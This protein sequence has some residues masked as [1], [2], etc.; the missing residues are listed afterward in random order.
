M[1]PRAKAVRHCLP[2]RSPD[3]LEG[4]TDGYDVLLR[5]GGIAH[6]RPLRTDDRQALHELVDRSSERSAYLRFFTG[7]RS[8]AR[9]YMDRV[10]SD[11]YNGHALLAPRSVAVIGA[12]RD[13]RAVGHK[14]LRNLIDA[15]FEGPIHPVNPN[16]T[17]VAELTCHATVPDGV[18][19][20]VVAVPARHVLQ[21]A[22]DCA[23]AGV[24]GDVS[25]MPPPRWATRWI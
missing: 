18:D 17:E 5:D 7:G 10:T 9:S 4:K 13:E 12:G 23:N 19:L 1:V 11:K 6:V 14:V 3:S 25:G 24:A 15:G 8:T 22:R 2:R 16:A 21:V 20:A